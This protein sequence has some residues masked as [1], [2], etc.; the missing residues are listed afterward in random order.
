[1]RFLTAAADVPLTAL[2]T[3]WEFRAQEQPLTPFLR[4][5]LAAVFN[6]G[7]LQ[8]ICNDEPARWRWFCAI[9]AGLHRVSI[10]KCAASHS[11]F[12]HACSL[13]SNDLLVTLRDSGVLLC[14]S[15]ALFCR[16]ML[17]QP[18]ALVPWHDK[19]VIEKEEEN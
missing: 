19:A 6:V 18:A 15:S 16:V 12:E 7:E 10:A 1:M 11:K 4:S 14:C 8:I 5:P 17:D 2:A 3:A 13:L 9:N